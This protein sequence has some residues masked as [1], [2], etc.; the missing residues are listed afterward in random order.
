MPTDESFFSLVL[1]YL[2]SARPK[3]SNFRQPG[4]RRK[5]ARNFRRSSIAGE[6]YWAITSI[7]YDRPTEV[8]QFYFLKQENDIDSGAIFHLID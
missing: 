5:L 7:S 6:S 3:P 2:P 1:G 4:G 8:K